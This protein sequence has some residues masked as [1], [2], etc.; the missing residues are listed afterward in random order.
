MRV[1]GVFPPIATPFNEQGELDRQALADNVSLWNRFGLGGYVVAG[2]NGESALLGPREVVEAVRTVR[3]RAR[4]GTLVIAGT[5]RQSTMLTTDLTR[6]VA[7]AGADVALVMTP[8]FYGS[9]MSPQALQRYYEMVAD[10][11]PIPILIYNVPKFTHLNIEVDTVARIAPHPNIIGI[12]DSAGNIGQIIDLLRQCPEGFD[13]LVGNGPAFF[14]AL[15][16]G[17]C[18]GILA[19]ANVAPGECVAIWRAV[20]AG[21]QATAREI[22]FRLMAVAKAITSGYGVPGLKAA[23]DMLGYQGGLPRPPLLPLGEDGREHL[24]ALLADAGLLARGN[25]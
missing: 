22:H 4:P 10:A 7:E 2:S 16:V 21:E 13:V 24:S 11:A 23:L 9:Q 1:T 18:G 20:S 14:S 19:L 15:Q 3:A 8:S 17:A 12:K 25:K 6:A 5:G